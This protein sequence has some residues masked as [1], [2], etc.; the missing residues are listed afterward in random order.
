MKSCHTALSTGDLRSEG[1]TRHRELVGRSHIEEVPMSWT[2]ERIDTMKKLW[3]EGLSASQVAK[4]L[5]GGV[6]RNAVIS[7]LHR[8]GLSERAVPSQ[9]ARV[10]YKPP[11]A[12]RSARESLT[13]PPTA[14]KPEAVASTAV[15]EAPTPARVALVEQ[16]VSATILTLGARMCKWP[17]GDPEHKD[18]T[19][20][21]KR[22]G[23]GPYCG[24]HARVAYQP[25]SS[26]RGPPSLARLRR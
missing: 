17:I 14:A 15:A 5:A 13:R 24:E 7:K 12:A 16:P 10:A 4:Q 11:R 21:G 3:R 23:H 18:F 22:N 2:D 1:Y 25:Q 9:P 8:L 20:C 19:F 6:T 26:R